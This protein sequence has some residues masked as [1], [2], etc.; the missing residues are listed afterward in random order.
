MWLYFNQNG[1][2]LEVS[3]YDGQARAGTTAFKIYA[4]FE[5][6]DIDTVYT[7]AT[8]KLYKP[9]IDGGSYPIILMEK[10]DSV[11]F[12]GPN[13]IH[14]VHG[15]SY[16][17][18]SFD[19]S[20]LQSDNSPVVLLDT[21]GL[22]Y[23][24]ITLRD[25]RKIN[26]VGSSSFNVQ[27]GISSETDE[28]EAFDAILDYFYRH[29]GSGSAPFVPYV[30]AE[31]AL[32]LGNHLLIFKD[33]TTEEQ[34]DIGI[35]S[36]NNL[37]ISTSD[38]DILLTP[39]G[40]VKYKSYEV[41]NKNDLTSYVQFSAIDQSVHVGAYDLLFE[42]DDGN[43]SIGMDNGNM[44]LYTNNGNIILDPDGIVQYNGYEIVNTSMLPKKRII[45]TFNTND[46]AIAAGQ[47]FY[48]VNISLQ[49]FINTSD[50]LIITWGG[51]YAICPVPTLTGTKGNQLV[52]GMYEDDQMEESQNITGTY[53]LEG[54]WTR[55]QLY[56]LAAC[57]V[58]LY[59]NST[60]IETIT[61]GT[62]DSIGTPYQRN[63]QT[64]TDVILTFSLRDTADNLCPGWNGT[65]DIEDVEVWELIYNM[66]GHIGAAMLSD[67]GFTKFVRMKYI[68]N[69]T[70]TNLYLA[71]DSSFTPPAD[72]TGYVVNYKIV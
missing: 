28:M 40:I 22:W 21:P 66:E 71:L 51:S 2:L 56:P 58:T 30:G 23:A 39:A 54:S 13:G 35:K 9:D 67:A 7:Q 46:F 44:T 59:G 52:D 4:V 68:I 57:H 5:N 31:Y 61:N 34:G 64:Y 18:Y 38:G 47:N 29:Y 49:N 37:E 60:I 65:F 27:D 36:G 33:G 15:Q 63:G 70:K 17:C 10:E 26:V 45:G 42:D 8:L 32:D 19:F 20:D 41:V 62:I 43:A 25:A 3:E 14:F 16:K 50:L 55:D 72:Y 53:V 11:T 12:D 48:S 69:S 1:R 6:I 24:V